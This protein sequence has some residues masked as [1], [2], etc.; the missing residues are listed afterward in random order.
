MNDQGAEERCDCGS[1]MRTTSILAASSP[2]VTSTIYASH[3]EPDRTGGAGLPCHGP[4]ER[5]HEDFAKYHALGADYLV[6]DPHRTNLQ[7]TAGV[8]RLLCAATSG[9][10]RTACCSARLAQSSLLGFRSYEPVW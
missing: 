2:L 7:P 9:S 8:V 10:G 4:L 6:L 1:A 3:P 5:R